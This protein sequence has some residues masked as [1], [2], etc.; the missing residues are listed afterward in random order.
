M[1]FTPCTAV[2]DAIPTLQSPRADAALSG[3]HGTA[4]RVLRPHPRAPVAARWPSGPRVSVA[5]GIPFVSGA[6]TGIVGPTRACDCCV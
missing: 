1:A 5:S 2:G 4:V 3:F 6:G